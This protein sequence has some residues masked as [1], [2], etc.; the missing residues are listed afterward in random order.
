MAREA[1]D[2]AAREAEIAA[3]AAGVLSGGTADE[4]HGPL[5]SGRVLLAGDVDGSVA[6]A[7]HAAGCAV[8]PWQRWAFGG[9]PAAAWPPEGAF[10]AAVLRLPRGRA[11]LSMDVNALAAR[12]EPGAPF[13][14]YGGNDE[15][16]ASAGGHLGG[17]VEGLETLA[18]KRRARVLRGRRSAAPARGL[19]ED[20]REVQEDGLVSYPGL[21]AHGRL[22]DGTALLLEALPELKAT[23]RVLDVGCGAGA[24]GRAVRQRVPEA[25]ITLLDVD[26]LAL[27]AARQNVP[28]ADLLLSD[29]LAGLGPRER[30]DLVVSN[31][32][33]HRGHRDDHRMLAELVNSAPQRLRIDGALLLVTQR[34]AGV[35]TL[36]KGA[37]A[38][39]A[40]RRETPAYQVWQGRRP[41]RR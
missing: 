22:D 28:D 21:F 32:P 10:D 19:L 33:L 25:Q 37:F 6:A 8:V 35:A 11:A 41:L 15:G 27:H 2:P 14:I 4:P 38:E 24:I 39:A 7:L 1:V 29:G 20:W 18:I 36:M 23:A 34:S 40:V 13:W 9:R 5:P 26:A 17:L 12:L 31:P 3:V 16:I 30:F